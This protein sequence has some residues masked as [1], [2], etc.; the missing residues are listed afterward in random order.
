MTQAGESMANNLKPT[1]ATNQGGINAG[2]NQRRYVMG[3]VEKD[4]Y[5]LKGRFDEW[6]KS[7]DE[8]IEHLTERVEH[9]CKSQEKRLTEIQ[10]DLQNEHDER[11][12]STVEMLDEIKGVYKDTS[13]IK[14]SVAYLN[15]IVIGIFAIVSMIY[16]F[17]NYVN[18]EKFKLE[19]FDQKTTEQRINEVGKIKDIVNSF[20]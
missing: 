11:L 7:S 2:E 8:K 1:D 4:V 13:G 20:K 5:E 17:G 16:V 3:A 19:H 12:R 10:S 18:W 14:K 6:A 9:N 15:F